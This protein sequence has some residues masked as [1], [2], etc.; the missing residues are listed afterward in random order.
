MKIENKTTWDTKQ[1]KKILLECCERF[2][3]DKDKRVKII[4]RGRRYHQGVGGYAYYNSNFICLKFPNTCY[5][6][7]AE[8]RSELQQVRIVN[9]KE[10]A[11]TFV[12]EAL[13]NQNIRHK[14]M[15]ELTDEELKWAEEFGIFRKQ[16]EP[17]SKADVKQI[18][19]QKVLEKIKEKESKLK[20]LSNS[21]KKLYRKREYYERGR[22]G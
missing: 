5:V 6:P 22:R 12:H 3:I 9:G 11:S 8:G 10:V 1:I 18:R 13:H 21:L 17:K 7:S 4:Y 16:I 20:R 14:D 15:L 19:Y 2:G